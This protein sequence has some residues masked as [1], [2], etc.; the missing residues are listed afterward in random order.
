MERRFGRPRPCQRNIKRTVASLRTCCV[1]PTLII[2]RLPFCKASVRLPPSEPMGSRSTISLPGTAPN[3]VWHLAEPSFFDIAIEL[4]ARRLAPATINLRLAAVRRLAYEASDNGLLSP[5]L[6]AS[7]R[8]VEGAK[9]LGVRLGNWLTCA[10]GRRLLDAPDT[11]NIKG[12]RDHAILALLLGCG[13]RRAELIALKLSDLQQR[14]D[15]WAIIDLYGKGGHVRTVP[16]PNWVK[17]TVDAWLA[18]ARI[19]DGF[20]FRCVTHSGTVWGSGISEKV[21]WWVVRQYAKQAAIEKLAPHDLRRT[22]ARLCHSAGGEL[23]QIQFLLGHRSVET[24]ERYLGSRQRIVHAVNDKLGIEPES[25]LAERF[26]AIQTLQAV[27]QE[28]TAHDEMIVAMR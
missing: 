16:V 26:T 28:W 24:T 7:I 18:A 6:A 11:R 5:D 15:H 22:C 20:I 4:E 27:R 23:E 14:D 1:C 8:R 13:L 3:R 10:Q 21:V 9:K 2:P 25:A 19:E 12:K 17:A